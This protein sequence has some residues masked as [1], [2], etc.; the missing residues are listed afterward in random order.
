MGYFLV[1]PS[2]IVGLAMLGTTATLSGVMGVTLTMSIGGT[3][4]TVLN[5]Y[6]C[7]VLCADGFMLNNNVMT[8]VGSLIDASGAILSYIMC[9]AMNRWL[10]NVILGG[11]GTGSTGTGK[12]MEITGTATVWDV[13]QTVHAIDDAYILC[14]ILFSSTRITLCC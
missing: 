1:D 13:D 9:V 11:F 10:P 6:S 14:L 8:V 2:L 12:P 3:V 5:S 7:W 4:I